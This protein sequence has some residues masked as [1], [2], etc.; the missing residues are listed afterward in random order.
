M[1]AG[2]KDSILTKGQIS[3]QHWDKREPRSHSVAEMVHSLRPVSVTGGTT[4]GKAVVDR[5][6]LESGEYYDTY[7]QVQ[8]HVTLEG[9][10]DSAP[11]RR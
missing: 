4:S 6:D 11:D 8:G 2:L 1:K 10:P 9:S 3:L 5:C 7:R